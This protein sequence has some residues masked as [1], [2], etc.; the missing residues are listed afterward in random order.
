MLAVALV[1]L[2]QP[3]RAR[4]VVEG[5]VA[6]EPHRTVWGFLARIPL[7]VEAIAKS[8]AEAL[9]IVSLPR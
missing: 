1:K 7:P 8:H 6:I 2:G 5:L 4:R 9:A 3:E